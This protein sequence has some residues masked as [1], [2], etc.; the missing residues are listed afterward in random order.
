MFPY[1][2][3][4]SRYWQKEKGKIALIFLFVI[5]SQSF[6]LVEPYFFATIISKYMAH[7]Y[8]FPSTEVFFKSL[9]LIVVMWVGVAFA[10]RIFKN[11]QSY[12]V[13]TVADRIGI[14]VLEHAYSHVLQ[15]PM[16]FHSQ[17]KAGELFRKITKARDDVT[18]LFTV[19]FDKIF[20]NSFSIV[21][22]FF[23]NEKQVIPLCFF[24]LVILVLNNTTSMSFYCFFEKE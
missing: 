5:L 23:K 7:P 20:Q 12:Y 6:S 4:L 19:M 8:D 21:V 16:T 24:L 11:L 17:E 2:K 13:A 14:N 3:F 18:A 1:I 22:V 9:T 10:A 15:L